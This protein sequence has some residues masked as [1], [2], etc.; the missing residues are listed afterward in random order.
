[1]KERLLVALTLLNLGMLLFQVARV[2][3]VQA[4]TLPVLRGRGL[5]LV[6]DKGRLRAEIKIIPA[7]A[8]VKMPDGSVGYPETVQ[9]RLITSQ[10]APNVK[11]G[12]NEDGSGA[13]LVGPGG[14]VQIISRKNEPF[15]RVVNTDARQQV[16]KQQVLKP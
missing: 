15:V 5:E 12:T 4:G 2:R 6:D 13:S 10:G 9:L 16:V 1:M 8:G 14:Y 7:E 3:P 11:L